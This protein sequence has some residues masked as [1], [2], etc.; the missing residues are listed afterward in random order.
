M[1]VKRILFRESGEYNDMAIRPYIANFDSQRVNEFSHATEHGKLLLPKNLAGLSIGMLQP[2]AESQGV[3]PIAEGWGQKRFMFMMEVEIHNTDRQVNSMVISGYTDHVGASNLMGSKVNLD[4]NM[5]LYFNSKFHVRQI[6]EYGS[7]GNQWGGRV[8]DSFQIVTRS[9]MG[10]LAA[11]GSNGTM[12]MRPEDVIMRGNTSEDFRAFAGEKGYNDTRGGFDRS[13]MKLSRRNNTQ[14]AS[15]LSLTL[16]ALRDS[17][18]DDYLEDNP[19][20]RLNGARAQVKEH[21][22]YNDKVFE[23]MKKDSSVMED[24]YI[25]WGDLCHMN[26]YIDEIADVWFSDKR[27][28]SHRR[29]DSENWGGSDNETLAATIIVNAIPAYLAEAMYTEVDF[30]ITN[31]TIG[32]EVVTQVSKLTPYLPGTDV[33]VNYNHLMSKIEF[34]LFPEVLFNQQM[35]LSIRVQASLY[36]ETRITIQYDSDQP[37]EFVYPTFC[38]AV[39]S[40]IITNN[41]EFVDNLSHDVIELDR[42]LRETANESNFSSDRAKRHI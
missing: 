22:I 34:E 13:A 25:T 6:L 16:S 18:E 40:P 11:S 38:D 27:H 26:P 4:E 41:M 32:S 1:K 20:A 14:S 10:D 9:K 37:A 39:A 8:S 3:A 33:D 5:R 2:A 23:E 24:G 28:Q 30:T 12:T 29:G 42:L 15:Y 35:S 17:V 7:R 36:G 19:A 31:D 21:S